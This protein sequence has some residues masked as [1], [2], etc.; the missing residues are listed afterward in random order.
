MKIRRF[1]HSATLGLN[2][3][4]SKLIAEGRT[5]YRFGFG[6]SPFPPPS[7]V[8]ESLREATIRND[9][10][11]VQGLP[12]LRQCIARFHSQ[13]DG[14]EISP[15]SVLVGAG[16]KILL[17][18]TLLA[19][20]KSAVVLPRPSWVTYAQQVDLAGHRLLFVDTT[21][22]DRWRI[23]PERLDALWSTSECHGLEKILILN[24]PGNPDGLAYTSSEL[25]AMAD[26]LRA[27]GAWAV[28]D[29]I[30]APL[31]YIGEHVSIARFYPE[32][33]VVTTGLSKWCG[34]GGW[35]L[36]VQ[37]IPENQDGA[38][39][40]SALVALAGATYSCAPTPVQIAA[41]A[42]YVYDEAAKRHLSS[43]QVILKAAEATAATAITGSDVR[44]HRGEGGFYLFL[45][46]SPGR[47][48]LA[49][50]GILSDASLCE[51]LLA[52]T[53]V[54]LLP[55]SAFNMRDSDLTARLA[56]VDFDGEGAQAE[57][58][59]G[60]RVSPTA[61]ADTHFAHMRRGLGLLKDWMAW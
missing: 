1:E 53:G 36:G 33:T 7:S 4:C 44:F 39:L 61:V 59:P 49:D 47:D 15:E 42:A 16:S 6:E 60:T 19:M 57:F 25:S 37:F 26:V 48:R 41:C 28:S 5:I 9:Y 12:E 22:D 13:T 38:E 52:D 35:R 43:Q 50:R 24:S 11:P 45:D 54:A 2:E 3:L 8:I 32:R 29:E 51:R 27:H 23:D 31:Q 58:D 40:R 14:Y 30:Y 34:A 46:F 20:G 10:A 21:F 17:L 55:G 56:F 18:N